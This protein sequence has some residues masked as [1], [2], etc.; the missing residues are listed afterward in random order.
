MKEYKTANIRNVVLL[1]HGGS[2]KTS[3]A[4]AMLYA[5]GGATRLG[6]VEEGT[7]VSDF[8]PEEVRRH[9]SISTAIV[10]V[11]WNGHKIN[12][13]DAPGYTDFVGEVKGAIRAADAALVLVDA[14]SGVEVGTELSWSY[15]DEEKLPR[16]VIIAKMDRENARFEQ[17]L[18]GLREAFNANFAVIQ[19]P[20]GAQHDF[21]GVV[22]VS[23]GHA[24]V[25]DK[26]Q[27][28]EV[29]ANMKAQCDKAYETLVE[30]AAEGDDE[31][32]MKFL[33]GEALTEDEVHRGLH[34]AVKAGKVVPVFVVAG[35]AMQGVQALMDAIITYL[36]SPEEGVERVATKPN[37]DETVTLRADPAGP[38]AAQV[39]KSV[40]D[41]YG[42][43][44]YFRVFSGTIS[45]D[46]R[47]WNAR[48]ETEER[49]GQLQDRRGK[50]QINVDKVIAGD[51]GVAM[52]LDHTSTGDTLSS[53]RAHA[54]ILPPITYPNP[55]YMA[56]LSPR[57]KTDLDKMGGAMQR[58]VEEDP[59][60]RV[61]REVDTGET[62]MEGMGESHIDVA[63]RKLQQKFGVNVDSSVPK[64]PYRETITRKIEQQGRHKKQSGG[65]GQFGDVHIRF[66]PLERGS[67]FEFADEVVGGSVPRQFI[68]AVE[69]GLREIMD[70]GV[71]A[72]YPTVDFRAALYYGSSHPVDSSEMAFKLASH[73]AFKEGLPKAGP[74]LLE[75][76]MHV[77][78]TVPQQYAGDI[79]GD[80]NQRRGRVLGID[81]QSNKAVIE[82]EVPLAEMMRYATDL[83]SMT[84]GRGIYTMEFVRYE[85]VPAHLTSHIVDAR[86][87]EL[88][89]ERG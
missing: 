8:E 53:D 5:S 70:Q 17:A 40:A 78:I 87:K 42:K 79:M 67:G 31:Y 24:I 64:V 83:R 74:V 58:L 86:K 60:L 2:G 84:Q 81:Q 75:P 22:D 13:I 80:M 12:V 11:E 71:V 35:T 20:I 77:V 37:N 44:S 85:E 82:A 26:G 14:S 88:A 69:K 9:I 45:S 47:V 59:T 25:G 15:L 66:E 41:P 3:L 7:T 65:R 30:A 46:S 55:V 34:L 89:E 33:D 27:P 61:R 49:L 4:E 19:I 72:G 38:L 57:T 39:F 21:K 28:G 68:P 43:L 29:P 51:I 18:A 56:A 52:K 73:I 10:P 23:N 54:L 1:G 32:L 16:A 62:I 63:M 76:I 36:P 50:E 6:K 48:S